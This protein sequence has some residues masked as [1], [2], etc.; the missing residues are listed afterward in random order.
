M[1]EIQPGFDVVSGAGGRWRR[2]SNQGLSLSQNRWQKVQIR[3]SG[4]MKYVNSS[5]DLIVYQGRRVEQ[6][7]RR[8][9]G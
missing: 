7:A 6:R 1:F 9:S 4:R 2:G 8:W 3:G 5:P